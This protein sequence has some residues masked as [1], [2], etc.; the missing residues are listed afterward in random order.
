MAKSGFSI[1]ENINC[2][3]HR[4]NSK[5]VI[6]CVLCFLQDSAVQIQ[7]QDLS[8]DR[9]HQVKKSF[10]HINQEKDQ[11]KLYYLHLLKLYFEQNIQ[12][13]DGY[14]QD[15]N[16]TLQL[17]YIKLNE[18]VCLNLTNILLGEVEQYLHTND[19]IIQQ[20]LI[21]VYKKI[22]NINLNENIYPQ[23]LQKF[24]KN[25]IL[26]KVFDQHKKTNLRKQS[27]GLQESIKIIDIRSIQ[28]IQNQKVN[29]SLNLEIDQN[30]KTQQN[31]S[32]Q[33]KIQQSGFLFVIFIFNAV[34][35][36]LI[37]NFCRINRLL[38]FRIESEEE[39][40]QEMQTAQD[41]RQENL[42][43]YQFM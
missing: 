43:Q 42:L 32:N 35:L 16:I 14:L 31:I 40:L 23:T 10:N 13:L 36:A 22:L 26:V 33:I 30:S 17:F 29:K 41:I 24:N 4:V 6:Y 20:N 27:I 25:E 28:Q 15:R 7:N 1:I 34:A 5:E 19:K 8:R 18:I 3:Q 2:N 21:N 37:I 9:Y 11:T 39:Q 12:H 38:F